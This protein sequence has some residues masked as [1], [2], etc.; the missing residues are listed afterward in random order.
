VYQTAGGR[1]RSRWPAQTIFVSK[2]SNGRCT[3]YIEYDASPKKDK[4]DDTFIRPAR[5]RHAVP[6]RMNP[7]GMPM[8]I[9]WN[10]HGMEAG[11]KASIPKTTTRA[12]TPTAVKV[13]GLETSPFRYSH[14]DNTPMAKRR[15]IGAK[16]TLNSVGS[17]EYNNTTDPTSQFAATA[18]PIIVFIINI[19]NTT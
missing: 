10:R 1:T 18:D 11:S 13:A 6:R 9:D 17:D 14:P 4:M 16:Y 19:E 8:S 3:I 15:W 7:A 2:I 5:S 12:N